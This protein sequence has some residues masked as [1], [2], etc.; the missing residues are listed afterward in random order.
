MKVLFLF[1]LFP[2][3]FCTFK[4]HKTAV[5][6]VINKG[7]KTIDSVII[8]AYMPEQKF[9]TLYPD[10]TQNRN[11]TIEPPDKAEGGFTIIVYQKDSIVYAG[12]FGY[13]LN[14][15]WIKNKYTVLISADYTAREE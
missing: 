3:A 11:I 9:I 13:Y 6:T 5:L 7:K 2:A 4:K 1:L 10:S 8:R 15:D 12:Q 14:A